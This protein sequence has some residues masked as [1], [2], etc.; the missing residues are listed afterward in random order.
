MQAVPFTN[1]RRAED[2]LPQL[3]Y[4]DLVRQLGPLTSLRVIREGSP[5]AMLVVARLIDRSRISRSGIRAGEL[6]EALEA[7]RRGTRWNPVAA[8]ENALELAIE[9]AQGYESEDKAEAA[10]YSAR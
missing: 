3:S 7:Y 10:A 9:T 2:L 8:V 6:R 5:S 4:R 1:A